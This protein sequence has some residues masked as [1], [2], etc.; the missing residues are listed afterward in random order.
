MG[1]AVVRRRLLWVTGGL[2]AVAVAWFG[3]ALGLHAA[4]AGQV[5]PGTQVAGVRIGGMS[6]TEARE[7]LAPVLNDKSVTLAYRGRRFTLDAEQLGYQ[8]DVA[9][10]VARAMDAG[11]SGPANGLLWTDITSLWSSR[12]VTAVT[13]VDQQRLEKSVASIA[14]RVERPASYGDLSIEAESLRVEVEPPRPAR[15]VDRQAAAD[16]ILAALRR[17]DAGTVPL[18][19][20]TEKV[21]K[22]DVRAVAAAARKY[23]QQPLRLKG[24]G[25]TV[26]VPPQELAPLLTVE[27][28]PM[29]DLR[30][31]L[32]VRP[33][34]LSD[35]VDS[36]ADEVAQT[37]VD[38]EISAP[39]R[40]V[41]LDEQGNLTWSPRDAAVEVDP[42]KAGRRLRRPTTADAI[43][44]AIREG[45]HAGKL[46]LRVAH[47]DLPTA[48][49]REVDSLIGTFTTYFDCCEPRVTN[50]KRMAEVVDG[51]IVMPGEEFSLNGVAGERT[52]S[53]GYV[54]APY[55]F[56]GKLVPDVGGGVSQF[57][58]T[59]YN[60]AFFAGVD[61][62][63][64][65]PHSYYISRYPVG[66]EST[67]NYPTI[68]LTWINDTDAPILVRSVATDTSLS[69][70]L[71]GHNGGRTVQATTGSKQAWSEGD[72]KITVTRT[73]TYSDGSTDQSADT[74]YYDKPPEH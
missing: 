19:V 25:T 38:A 31:R 6:P 20:H 28:V 32:G 59:T 22:D 5:L 65:Q 35:L 51:T 40:P 58:T 70:S 63:Y 55:I 33:R 50:I 41:V 27:P 16:A 11:R 49:A 62:T 2:G 7:R 57:S 23:L 10:T 53:K 47:A 44:A 42:G 45:R 15:K 46:P 72:F 39:A 64:H 26:T 67:L 4:H 13:A 71:Y 18:P 56:R 14:Q 68:D 21:G 8:V 17:P 74:V 36:L 73:V 66:R 54:P 43:T 24:K 34:A 37:P 9:T 3:L 30:V 48:E 60:A 61:I 1:G 12:V 52:R 69:V 29:R